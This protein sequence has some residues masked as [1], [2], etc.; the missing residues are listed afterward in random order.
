MKFLISNRHPVSRYSHVVVTESF[1]KDLCKLYEIRVGKK[2]IRQSTAG[3]NL[4]LQS[5]KSDIY[6]AAAN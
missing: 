6:E 3:I 2:I 4:G 5:I 1:L